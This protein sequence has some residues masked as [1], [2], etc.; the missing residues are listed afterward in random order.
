MA[1]FVVDGSAT[2]TNVVLASASTI[3]IEAFH[4]YAFAFIR[5]HSRLK[6]TEYNGVLEVFDR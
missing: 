5:V 6:I 4:E 1:E 3:L 2:E